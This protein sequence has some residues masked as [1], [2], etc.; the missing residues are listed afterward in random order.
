MIVSGILISLFGNKFADATIGYAGFLASSATLV[1]LSFS[2]LANA[3][4]WY[5]ASIFTI[6]LLSSAIIGINITR[7]RNLGLAVLAGFC[8]IL[9]GFILTSS[10]IISGKL[11]FWAVITLSL[12]IWFY[13]AFKSER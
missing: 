2:G 1:N 4:E 7:V 13:T 11:L 12:A 9:F 5:K 3:E 6:C 8:G 10:F